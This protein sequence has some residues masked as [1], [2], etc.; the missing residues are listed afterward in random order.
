MRPSHKRTLHRL[1]MFLTAFAALFVL[2]SAGMILKYGFPYLFDDTQLVTVPD[3]CG[4]NIAFIELPQTELFQII[5][6]EQFS[7]A[8]IGTVLMQTPPPGS[9]RKVLKGHRYVTLTLTVSKGVETVPVPDVVGMSVSEGRAVLLKQG[10]CPTVTAVY[11]KFPVGSIVSQSLPPA[12]SSPVGTSLVLS[13]SKGEAVPYVRIPH[14]TGLSRISAESLLRSVGLNIGQIR[15]RDSTETEDR[16]LAQSPLAFGSIPKGG[17]ID[18]TVSR[19]PEETTT[20]ETSEELFPETTVPAESEPPKAP[21]SP[22]NTDEPSPED[23][24]HRMFET[25][26]PDP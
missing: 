8:P 23:L 22:Q 24:I 25:L 10:F 4:K 26:F 16:V 14:L 1:C 9:E 11:S 18:L 21:E 15:Y 3:L 5:R 12:I 17:H 19:H 20:L 2:I 6:I 7:D 13:V